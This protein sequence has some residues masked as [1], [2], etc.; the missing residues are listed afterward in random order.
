MAEQGIEIADD[1]PTLERPA[2]EEVE[3]WKG[4]RLDEMT[5]AN[6]GRVDGVF[7][8]AESGEPEWLVARMGRFGHHT[9]VPGRDAVEGVGHIW[10]PFTRETI[11]RAPKVDPITS[12][13]ANEERALLDHYGMGG[14]AGR[15]A[16][17]S[18]RDPGA[19]SLRPAGQA[20]SS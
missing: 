17:L 12:L 8:D 13:T 10:V 6:V 5:G 16:E 15:A 4:H 20:E 7:V 18:G 19:V 2:L 9:L 11:R 1:A 14:G 3:A